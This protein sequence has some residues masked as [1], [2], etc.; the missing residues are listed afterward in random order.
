MWQIKIKKEHGR[1]IG[2]MKEM[3][4]WKGRGH[5][6][7][8]IA[9]YLEMF[10]NGRIFTSALRTYLRDPVSKNLYSPYEHQ[11]ITLGLY[12]LRLLS[13]V[14]S[15]IVHD[16]FPHCQQTNKVHVMNDWTKASCVHN[17]NFFDFPPFSCLPSNCLLDRDT[18]IRAMLRIIRYLFHISRKCHFRTRNFFFFL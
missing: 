10:Q 12:A 6:L 4:V 9:P 18:K 11:S 15:I 13:F 8:N 3:K 1:T 17:M 2:I 14:L 16:Y 5:K 7:N